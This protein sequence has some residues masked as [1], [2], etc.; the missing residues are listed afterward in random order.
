M[1][2]PPAP[3]VAETCPATPIEPETPPLVAPL[4]PPAEAPPPP[5]GA[6]PALPAKAVRP[7]EPKGSFPGP[8]YSEEQALTAMT[9]VATST[10]LVE[11]IR[12]LGLM[13]VTKVM[14]EVREHLS[15]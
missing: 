2:V 10:A 9:P 7:A 6:V 13:I 1:P 5:T 4:T 15:V 12:S 14:A 3:E 8:L 11:R